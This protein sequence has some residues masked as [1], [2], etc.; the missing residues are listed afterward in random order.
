MKALTRT[1]L[2]LA[3]AVSLSACSLAP[4]YVRPT[5]VVPAELPQEGVYPRAASD[6]PDV[7]EIGWRDFF[8]DAQLRA[9][10]ETGLAN[11]RDLRVAMANVLQAR[12]QYRVQRADRLPGLSATGNATFTDSATSGA[13]AGADTEL[14]S[15]NA[16]ISA[17]EVDLFGRVRNLSRAALERYLA[18]EEG[19]RAA[20]ISL[21]GEIATAWLTLASD[22]DQL[23]LSQAALKTFEQTLELTRARFRIGIASELD[24]R[25]AETNY[26]SAR[27]DVAVLQARIAQDRNALDLLV[28]GPV[29]DGQLPAGLGEGAAT[30]DA[31]PADISSD[32]LLRRPDVL[33]AE[34]VLIAANADIGAARAAFFPRISLTGLIGT[35]STG[36]SGLFGNGSFNYTATPS[37]TLPIFDGG[38]SAGNLAGAK[39]A[40]QAAV[41]SYEKAIQTAFR[42]VA[43]AL[44]TSGTIGEQ[45]SAQTARR[46]AARV[47]S[48]LSDAR[49]R[50]G[51][52]SFLT[53]LDAQ[54]V[55]YGAEQQLQATRLARASNRVA[56]Y[57]ALGGGLK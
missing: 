7:T 13:V 31:L 47:A 9:V 56:L 3:G 33:Q 16:G 42:E 55:A 20:R 30:L 28:G 43:D 17:F 29:P 19:A 11:N 38:R 21:I 2:L 15:V 49:Y 12:A 14:Y 45:V 32:I 27:N 40:Q 25:Q 54:R 52:D 57:H 18:S 51:I 37:V 23:A 50:A 1:G 8:T 34:H 10:I 39:A 26:Q 53:A 5:G 36:L 48:R 6:A 44:A 41:A 22:R 46:D 4:N 24:A 35:M